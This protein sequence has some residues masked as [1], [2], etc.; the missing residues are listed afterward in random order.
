MAQMSRADQLRALLGPRGIPGLTCRRVAGQ[1]QAAA[2]TA[3]A[4]PHE[5]ENAAD[6]FAVPV[7][8]NITAFRAVL[9]R[10]AASPAELLASV[11]R[12]GEAMQL[13]EWLNPSTLG[14]QD[15]KLRKQQALESCDSFLANLVFVEPY[16]LE[17]RQLRHDDA[18][19]LDSSTL[20]LAFR[21][22]EKCETSAELV[23]LLFLTEWLGHKDITVAALATCLDGAGEVGGLMH[24]AAWRPIKTSEIAAEEF[25]WHVQHLVVDLARNG[26]FWKTLSFSDV[27]WAG[28][29]QSGWVARL[30]PPP[31]ELRFDVLERIPTTLHADARVGL[32]ELMMQALLVDAH[33]MG[34]MG[35]E[36]HRILLDRYF[37]LNRRVR[38][39]LAFMHHQLKLVDSEFSI[40]PLPEEDDEAATT[41]VEIAVEPAFGPPLIEIVAALQER[42][43]PIS[44]GA[45]LPELAGRLARTFQHA[46][47]AHGLSMQAFPHALHR[48]MKMETLLDHVVKLATDFT[49]LPAGTTG[50]LDC[51]EAKWRFGPFQCAVQLTLRWNH[52]VVLWPALDCPLQTII[53]RQPVE[54]TDEQRASLSMAGRLGLLH[55]ACCIAKA[56][57]YS[58]KPPLH[59]FVIT[60]WLYQIM[61]ENRT[62]DLVTGL[63]DMLK[64][65]RERRWPLISV[66]QLQIQ[67][68]NEFEKLVQKHE[69]E[70]TSFRATL[71]NFHYF[72]SKCSWGR[73]T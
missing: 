61:R 10:A 23:K 53:H 42:L 28:S 30:R 51:H 68:R 59:D 56:A 25:I 44:N 67:A 14:E 13:N 24:A 71:Q 26:L 18:M 31:R 39:C 57:P 38:A 36:V 29:G 5:E 15:L 17:W 41:N 58:E 73:E 52:R 33:R 7:Q 64:E 54:F 21:P 72:A 32:A 60:A 48:S 19:V 50:S 9:G 66:V 20:P 27:L 49:P 40:H 35:Q 63:Y 45:Q 43:A 1:C 6:C 3:G 69:N 4:T 65:W 16:P 12:C 37:G 62:N 22:M 2:A 46:A 8:N 11:A 55:G 47:W 70:G 34:V